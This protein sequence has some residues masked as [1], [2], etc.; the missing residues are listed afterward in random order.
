MSLKAE[1]LGKQLN[2]ATAAGLSP[3]ERGY[4]NSYE[5]NLFQ[6]LNPKSRADF[7]QGSG[8]ELR[9]RPV[10]PAKMRA[11]HSS[12]ALAVN[13][14]D[15]WVAG[16]AKPLM[17]IFGLAVELSDIRFEAQYSTGLPGNP[18]NLDVVFELKNGRTVGIE[19][20]FTEWLAPKSIRKPSF[21]DKYFPTGSNVWGRVGLPE[22]QHLAEEIRSKELV[23]RHLD[24]PQLMKH[25]LGL[26]T[27][28]RSEFQLFY[29]Y[30]DANGPEGDRHRE[31]IELFTGRLQ[32]EL[33]F[34]AFSYQDL[35]GRLQNCSGV[36]VPYLNYLRARYV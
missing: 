36:P 17:D 26:A 4:L 9:D 18:P 1:I 31:E 20:K 25:A 22:T 21:K 5:I 15:V 10:G 12:S 2:W 16:D 3:D 13:F 28:C 11:L 6:P 30:F 7:D 29:V 27:H 23:F 34:Q 19:S 35:I 24:A 32:T 33:G 14:F 8:S